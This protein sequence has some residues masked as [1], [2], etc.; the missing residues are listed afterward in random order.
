[1]RKYY[2]IQDEY[3][4]MHVA[5]YTKKGR[6]PIESLFFLH[7]LVPCIPLPKEYKAEMESEE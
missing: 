5:R 7:D 1:M 6:H 2:L 4:D 3:A